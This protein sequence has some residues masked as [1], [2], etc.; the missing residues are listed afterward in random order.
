MGICH[1]VFL[2]SFL[3][4]TVL[5]QAFPFLQLGEMRKDESGGAGQTV[6]LDIRAAGFHISWICVRLPKPGCLIS[7]SLGAVC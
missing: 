7:I 5:L 1:L 6:L 4:T 2:S 3:F